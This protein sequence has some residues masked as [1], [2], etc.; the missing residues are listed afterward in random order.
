MRLKR[1]CLVLT[2]GR[3][4]HRTLFL[5]YLLLGDN[6]VK[7]YLIALIQESL[8]LPLWRGYSIQGKEE[9]RLSIYSRRLQ[10]AERQVLS[11]CLFSSSACAV[12]YIACLL[13]NVIRALVIMYCRHLAGNPLTALFLPQAPRLQTPQ[14][15]SHR[16]NTP[17]VRTDTYRLVYV[18]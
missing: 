12:T 7:P 18:R 10:L 6:N 8:H 14:D 13:F 16:F 4:V 11:Y 5:Q 9:K 15:I 17:R 3:N 2:G 1:D